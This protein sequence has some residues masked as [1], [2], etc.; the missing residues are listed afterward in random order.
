MV[1]DVVYIVGIEVLQDGH[2]DAAVGDGCH[3]GDA[4]ACVVLAD[5]G[6]L[7]TPPQLAVLEKQ[8]QTGNLLRH[9]SVCVTVVFSVVGVA[10]EFPVFPK[11][12]LVQL[13]EILFYHCTFY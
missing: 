2:H 9:F 10:G 12:V 3:V 4:P 13:D 6:Y 7:V 11:T 1:H 8:V 5:D